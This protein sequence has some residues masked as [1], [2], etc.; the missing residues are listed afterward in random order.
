MACYSPIVAYKPPPELGGAISFVERANYR[1]ITLPCG[2]CIG[3]RIDKQNAW[4]FRCMAEA[5]MHEHNHFITLTYDDEHY[6]DNESLDHKHWQL[7]AARLRQRLG[8]FRFFMC[9]EYGDNTQRAHYHA[10]LFGLNLPDL[11]PVYSVRSN[12]D[13]FS[14]NI[15]ADT[16]GKGFVS[17]G[18][19]TPSSAKYCAAYALK[20]VSHELEEERYSWVTRFGEHVIR[21]QPYGRMSLK[22]GIGHDWLVKYRTD[23]VNLG[24]VYENQY[25]KP[26]PKYFTK[27]LEKL[28]PIGHETAMALIQERGIKHHKPEEQTPERLAVREACQKAK[29]R[30]KKERSQ[31][32]I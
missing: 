1:S 21:R 5:S 29:V 6:P 9:G 7:F 22:P 3:C 15:L 18:R 17:V 19:V 13:I 14:S 28:D 20:R 25:R 8:P 32:A 10:L 16:W 2:G 24:G 23:I 4:G 30:F 12:Y 31:N 27:I 11:R 26:V